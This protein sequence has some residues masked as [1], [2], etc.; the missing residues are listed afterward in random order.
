MIERYTHKGLTWVDL[1]SPTGEEVR[2]VM[3]EFGV[4]PLVG[5]ELLVPTLRGKV[6]LYE[7]HIYLVLHFPAFRH[8]HT[9][10]GNQEIDFII[11]KDYLI[12]THYDT[13]D[14]IH[15][16]SKVFEVNSILDKSDI[17]N[18]AGFLFFYMI[19]KIYRSL[20]HELDYLDDRLE[21][22]EA[23]I[24][25]GGEQSMV[26]YLAG[27]NHD[28]LNFKQ[29][30][31]SHSEVLSSLEVAGKEFFGEK[32]SYHLRS[33]TGEYYKV[34][35]TLEGLKETMTDLRDTNDSL[36]SAKTNNIMKILTIITFATFPSVLLAGIFGMNAQATPFVG[37]PHDFWT[38]LSLM[39]FTTVLT[40]GFFIYKK[41]L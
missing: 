26:Q 12:T 23:A 28:L 3:E 7:N 24:F 17:G 33:I 9:K 38:I 15:K 10:D 34:S 1:E 30:L 39:L 2:Q 32:F 22:A 19:R 5:D 18:H 25:G 27:I 41:W 29:A 31:R 16:F 35:G 20:Y 21:E 6:D 11:G 36:L 4:H 8:S 13:I 14:P 40:F 37:T